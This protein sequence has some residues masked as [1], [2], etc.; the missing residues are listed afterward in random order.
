MS[1]SWPQGRWSEAGYELGFDS[2]VPTTCSCGGWPS[3]S[4]PAAFG[5]LGGAADD[6]GKPLRMH[7]HA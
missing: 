3:L 5:K 1:L 4:S 6:S 7:V 2:P